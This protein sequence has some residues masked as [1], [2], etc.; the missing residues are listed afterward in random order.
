MRPRRATV[1]DLRR[2][3]RSTLLSTLFFDGPL[4]RHELGGHTGLS[5]ATVSNVVGELIDDGLVVEAG[6]VESDGG[7][8]RVLLRVNPAYG[9][10]VGIDVGETGVTMEIF[11]LAMTRLATVVRPLGGERAHD[12]AV[13]GRMIAEGFG[14]L[15]RVAGVSDDSLIGVGIGVP[16]TVEQG[17]TVRVH[18]QTIG[19]DGVE[20]AALL[21]A[22]GIT[23]P[24]FV[25]NGAKTLGQA[26]MWFGAGRGTRHAVIALIGSGVGATVITDGTTYRGATSSAGEWGHTT[27]MFNGRPCRCGAL[28]CLEAYVGAEG[29]LDRYRRARGGRAIPRTDEQ[30]QLDFLLDSVERSSTAADIVAATVG[31]L[32]AG[33]SNLVNLFNPERIVLGGWAGVALGSRLLPEIRTATAAHALRHAY[34]QTSIVLCELGQDAVAVGAATLPVETLLNLGSD[35]RVRPKVPAI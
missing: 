7:R 27:L 8:P 5:A 22:E 33:I 11:D 16:G 2:R 20:L 1:R 18:A 14:E 35:P 4:S 10:V 29:I 9:H 31:Y 13:V 28:G 30:S 21:R 34:E 24:V 32:G 26:E 12:V 15:L 6:L 25:E 19:W 17:A 3:N 23:V